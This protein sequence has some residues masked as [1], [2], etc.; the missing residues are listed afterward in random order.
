MWTVNP[1]PVH[2]QQGNVSSYL[3]TLR[4]CALCR[5]EKSA[6]PLAVEVL[7]LYETLPASTFVYPALPPP[8]PRP[9]GKQLSPVRF[10]AMVV[11]AHRSRDRH[12]QRDRERERD[13]RERSRDHDS[14]SRRD[15]RH[16][17]RCCHMQDGTDWLNMYADCF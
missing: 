15:S 7:E 5:Q 2:P 12:R 17:E 3:G 8:P 4:R 10:R 11:S 9:L 16:S 13:R 6:G 1:L 14:D